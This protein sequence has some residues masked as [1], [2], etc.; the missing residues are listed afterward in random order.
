MTARSSSLKHQHRP[1]VRV[2]VHLFLILAI[3]ATIGPLI[4]TILGSFKNVGEIFRFPP[5]FLPEAPT[6]SNY[7]RLF[8]TPA[9]WAWIANTAAMVAIAV[10]ATL[11]VCS[12]AGYAFAKFRFPGSAFLFGVI[13]AS[14]SIPFAVVLT[15][16]FV[17]VVEVGVAGTPLGLAI[18]YLAPPL[19][20]IIMRQ[21]AIAA[22]PEEI[23]E[24]ARLDGAGEFRIFWSIVAPLLAPGSGALAIWAFFHVYNAY[25]WPIVISSR[26]N[27]FNLPAGLGALANGMAPAYG[28]TVAGAVITAIPPLVL[29]FV[30][31][32]RVTMALSAGAVKG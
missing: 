25:L 16:L 15:T 9:F 27:E 20:V 14:L 29:L 28:L 23:L 13:V 21:Y 7:E 1:M 30:L 8:D 5:T 10:A 6:L 11:L 22:V 32:H 31:R 19:G 2:G 3:I 12:L 24:A 17:Q 4:W 18:P 26:T